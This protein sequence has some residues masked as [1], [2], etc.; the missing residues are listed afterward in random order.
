M[1]T[2]PDLFGCPRALDDA[3]DFES[4]QRRNLKVLD[5]DS[6]QGASD[7]DEDTLEI[8]D[9]PEH[10]VL[11]D[12]GVHDNHVHYEAQ[13]DY[14]GEDSFTYRICNDDGLCDIATVTITVVSDNPPPD[15]CTGYNNSRI[16]FSFDTDRLDSERLD[17]IA[18]VGPDTELFLFATVP[19]TTTEVRFYLDDP[20][21]LGPPVNIDSACGYDF[22][23][24]GPDGVDDRGVWMSDIGTGFHTLTIA[25]VDGDGSTTIRNDR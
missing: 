2:C 17:G 15:V 8:I 21:R 16:R 18:F 20:N 10:A 3:Y 22:Q 12:F 9:P 11:A 6:V 13:E 25:V 24:I 14:V 4:G 19:E 7:L 5:N 1:V 23:L